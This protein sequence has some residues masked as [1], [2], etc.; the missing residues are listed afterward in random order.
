MRNFENELTKYTKS[1]DGLMIQG[2]ESRLGLLSRGFVLR[3]YRA[4]N[5]FAIGVP[6]VKQKEIK[7]MQIRLR[8]SIFTENNDR[9]QCL[10]INTWSRVTVGLSYRNQFFSLLNGNGKEPLDVKEFSSSSGL[11][12]HVNGMEI[13]NRRNK[14]NDPCNN[15]ANEQS[16]KELEDLENG[17]GCISQSW[18]SPTSLPDCP[19]KNAKSFMTMLA[20]GFK[21]SDVNG[22]LF[23]KPCR[24]IQNLWHRWSVDKLINEQNDTFSMTVVYTDL[25]F[26]EITFVPSRSLANLIMNVMAIIGF[27]LGFSMY[28]D[29]PN[30]N[31]NCLSSSKSRSETDKGTNCRYKLQRDK[32]AYPN[33]STETA[34]LIE[35][36]VAQA[37]ER[38][39]Y[40]N[41]RLHRNSF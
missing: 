40:H 18:N 11:V 21:D 24:Y 17:L 37:H 29:L 31:L 38:M 25:P 14:Q 34:E 1:I 19:K 26:K 28:K 36:R 32:S 2:E 16:I 41:K 30:I 22:K 3:R 23:D 13:I 9:N 6:F 35:I 4:M 27:V 5:C 10:K 33:Y 20:N 39:S 8:K 12:F 15:Y 7:S